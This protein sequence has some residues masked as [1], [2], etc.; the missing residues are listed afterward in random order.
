MSPD[1]EGEVHL[2]CKTLDGQPQVMVL[3][4]VQFIP[5]AGVNFILQGQ[6]HRKD[7]H[8][9]ETTSHRI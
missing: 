9:L 7:L 6:I 3:N 8:T 2:I 1:G 5:E 4:K